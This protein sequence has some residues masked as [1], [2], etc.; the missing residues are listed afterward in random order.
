[1]IKKFFVNGATKII[2]R[3][4]K[5]ERIIGKQKI[6]F[7]SEILDKKSKLRNYFKIKKYS[8]CGSLQR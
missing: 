1:M 7:F 5:I 4:L 8:D 3:V 6:Y 2:D